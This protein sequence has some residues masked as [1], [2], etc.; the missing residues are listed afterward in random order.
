MACNDKKTR[1]VDS[2]GNLGSSWKVTGYVAST[3][4][5]DDKRKVGSMEAVENTKETQRF[6]TEAVGHAHNDMV[7]EILAVLA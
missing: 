5:A 6:D 2:M 7:S 1:N 3:A 4:I